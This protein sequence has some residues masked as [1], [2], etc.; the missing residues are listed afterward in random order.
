MNSK[1]IVSFSHDRGKNSTIFFEGT[2]TC[3]TLLQ[4]FF[5]NSTTLTYRGNKPSLK[6]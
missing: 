1:K 5:S 3:T 2:D 6:T 4:T